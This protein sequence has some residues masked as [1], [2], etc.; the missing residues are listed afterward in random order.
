M[1]FVSFA[2]DEG[3]VLTRHYIPHGQKEMEGTPG[4]TP[5]NT[6]H[7]ARDPSTWRQTGERRPASK[8]ETMQVQ[9]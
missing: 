2:E 6:N 7:Q 8:K 3:R 4:E 9:G 5:I 1:G